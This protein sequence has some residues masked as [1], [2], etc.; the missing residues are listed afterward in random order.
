MKKG[1]RKD[2]KEHGRNGLEGRKGKLM[3]VKDGKGESK[4]GIHEKKQRRETED[5]ITE[6]EGID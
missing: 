4:G 6:G 5:K 1:R 2:E 3:A